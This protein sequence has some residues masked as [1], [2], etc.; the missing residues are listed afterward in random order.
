MNAIRQWLR[1]NS[2]ELHY[3]STV[4]D[5]VQFQGLRSKASSVTI[6][7]RQS[8]QTRLVSAL[9]ECGHVLIHARRRNDKKRRVAGCSFNEFWHGRGRRKHAVRLKL[10]TLQEEIAAWD[11]GEVLARRLGIRYTRKVFERCRARALLTYARD[12]K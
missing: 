11:Q 9:H 8:Y 3:S 4:A 10:S 7:R 12:C 6:N 1:R 5:E 2:S